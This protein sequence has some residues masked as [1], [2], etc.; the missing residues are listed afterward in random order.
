M[1]EP[2][3]SSSSIASDRAPGAGEGPRVLLV[4][5]EPMLAGRTARSLQRAGYRVGMTGTAD[6]LAITQR[7]EPDLVVLD[8]CPSGTIDLAL[9]RQLRSDDDVPIVMLSASAD[10]NDRIHGLREGADDFVPRPVSPTELTARVRCVLRRCQRRSVE[11]SSG[12]LVAGSVVVNERTRQVTVRGGTVAVTALEFKLLLY[13]VRRPFTSFDR[14]TL[15]EQVWGYTI[16]DGSTVTVHVRRL[17]EK[18]ELDPA[19][20]RLIR[21]VWG[22]GYAFHPH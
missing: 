13:F 2:L 15:L 3:E 21:T 16:G 20:P 6:A 4:G 18:I 1:L 11:E 19:S 22:S 7:S 10:E 17:R 8:V 5:L 14:A 12:S 9:F